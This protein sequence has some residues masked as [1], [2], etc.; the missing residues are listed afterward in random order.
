MGN[1]N[2]IYA[3]LSG[4]ISNVSIKYRKTMSTCVHVCVYEI[5]YV[6]I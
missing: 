6:N 3:M 4:L 5:L 2:D 1:K